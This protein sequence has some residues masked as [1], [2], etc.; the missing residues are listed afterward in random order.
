MKNFIIYLFLSLPI[1]GF[2]QNTIK[3][4][5]PTIKL[6]QP[7]AT[8]CGSD[9]SKN[10]RF[11]PKC[12]SLKLKIDTANLKMSGYVITSFTLIIKQKG[13]LIS[14]NFTGDSFDKKTQEQFLNTKKGTVF[15]ENIKVAHVKNNHTFFLR[16]LKVKWYT[17]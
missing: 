16:G 7:Y 14:L 13:S 15:F 17:K 8:F 3:V 9:G 12:K 5:K 10:I 1:I 4:K 11:I 6:S 2:S